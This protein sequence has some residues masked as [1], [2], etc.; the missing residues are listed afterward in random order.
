VHHQSILRQVPLF[1]TLPEAELNAL[2]A[3]LRE[4]RYPAQTALFEEGEK[5]ARFMIVLEGS[6]EIV[7]AR[8]TENE[9][10]IGIRGM[11]EFVGEMSLLNPDGLR[12]ATVVAHTDVKTLELTRDEFYE[13][14]HGRPTLL[15]EMLR[16]LSS[17]L[18]EAHDRTIQDLMEK[19]HSLSEAYE[20]LR[21][22]QEQI[23]QK[24][25][26]ERELARA[27]EIQQSMLPRKISRLAGYD[28]GAL[29]I[30]AR[31]IGG[32]LYDLIP[33]DEDKIG[34]VI[35]DV[36]GKGVP[37]ALFMALTQSLIR[38]LA[39]PDLSPADVLARVNRHLF[40]MN[41][42]G[43]FV[44]VLYGV[45]CKKSREFNYVRA[46]HEYPLVWKN[47]DE[48]VPLPED[49]GLPLGLFPTSVL[50]AQTLYMPAAGTMVFFTDGITEAMDE[51]GDFFGLERL[52]SVIPACTASTAQDLCQSIVA[53]VNAFQGQTPQTDDITLVVIKT[54]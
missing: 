7:K 41:V 44:T 9:R 5:G 52:E 39:H 23:I 53:K 16:V 22:A 48:R 21:A 36:S 17:R 1:A 30:P 20:S 49:R 37:A 33:L 27:H 40:E 12:T 38:A 29:M 4:C 28:I 3:H 50:Q 25:I 45:L 43:M 15:Y 6:V 31:S 35:G 19:N 47:T 51:N 10:L 42:G 34:I 54:S 11:G 18:S 32:D 8:Q 13:L 26:M 46:A 14:L 2:S 24:K